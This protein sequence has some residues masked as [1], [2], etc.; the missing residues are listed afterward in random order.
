[1]VAERDFILSEQG[2]VQ[3]PIVQ[4]EPM[5]A[6][7]VGDGAFSDDEVEE[8]IN[9]FLFRVHR[10]VFVLVHSCHLQERGGIVFALSKSPPR[11]RNAFWRRFEKFF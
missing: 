3:T 1:M 8:D 10:L 4:D 9:Q 6:P 11:K 2:A 7:Q 5:D